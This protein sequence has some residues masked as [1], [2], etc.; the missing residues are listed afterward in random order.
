MS[1]I[2]S[3]FED[4]LTE[5]MKALLAEFYRYL[6]K[7][8]LKRPR[9]ETHTANAEL[10][11]IQYH[12]YQYLE[13]I[14][15]LSAEKI[16]DFLWRWYFQRIPKPNHDEWRALVFT[17]KRLLIFLYEKEELPLCSYESLSDACRFHEENPPE[18][19]DT[20]SSGYQAD[21]VRNEWSD[22]ISSP[23]WSSFQRL[24]TVAENTGKPRFHSLD[25][26]LF[27]MDQILHPIVEKSGKVIQLALF[28]HGRQCENEPQPAS[29]LDPKRRIEVLISHAMA[30]HRGN[31]VFTRWLERYDRSIQDL[32]ENSRLTLARTDLWLEEFL[33]WFGGPDISVGTLDRAEDILD[34]LGRL[35]WAIRRWVA[36]ELDLDLREMCV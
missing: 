36:H 4:D 30:L 21:A 8:G 32:C 5:R 3:R 10:F 13:D 18:S 17:L 11:L 34:R 22:L 28:M 1:A 20:N 25:D 6:V 16:S 24:I 29:E 27:E 19:R 26:L 14:H 33:V 2:L 23:Q 15:S 31:Q 35:L 12:A 7:R 9:A